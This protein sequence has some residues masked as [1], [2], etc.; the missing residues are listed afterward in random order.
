MQDIASVRA[1]T[2]EGESEEVEP[3]YKNRIPD[4]DLRE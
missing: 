3:R 4:D 2:N 1:L